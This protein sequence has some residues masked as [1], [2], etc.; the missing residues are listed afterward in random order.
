MTAME[1]ILLGCALALLLWWSTHELCFTQFVFLW[2]AVFACWWATAKYLEYNSITAR[3][4]RE[5]ARYKPEP[6]KT[7]NVIRARVYKR[8]PPPPTSRLPDEPP[9]PV[10]QQTEV[11]PPPTSQP[12]ASRP[13]V[14][15][16]PVSEPPVSGPPI[17][18]PPVS[19][20]Q[21]MRPQAAWPYVSQLPGSCQTV[22]AQ[23]AVS[24]VAAVL[25]PPPSRQTKMPRPP[26]SQKT[27]ELCPPTSQ[28]TMESCPPTSQQTVELSPPIPQ[29]SERLS[30][31][32]LQ[33]TAPQ[34][35]EPP[36]LPTLQRSEEPEDLS[37]RYPSSN[38]LALEPIFKMLWT[39]EKAHRIVD[40]KWLGVL[41]SPSGAFI[42]WPIK[43]GW[44]LRRRFCFSPEAEAFADRMR[45]KPT[46][47]ATVSLDRPN[48]S[49]MVATTRSLGSVL[50][51]IYSP[52]MIHS[53]YWAYSSMG[54]Q[55]SDWYVEPINMDKALLACFCAHQ[56]VAKLPW[57]Y[58]FNCGRVEDLYMA[59]HYSDLVAY[60]ALNHYG[61]EDIHE[62]SK[63]PD[64]QSAEPTTNID[65]VDSGKATSA[66]LS[67][68]D[69]DDS[70]SSTGITHNEPL[71]ISRQPVE[72]VSADGAT[73]GVAADANNAGAAVQPVGPIAST[74]RSSSESPASNTS[75]EMAHKSVAEKVAEND[76]GPRS[77]S[78]ARNIANESS[79]VLPASNTSSRTDE[80]CHTSIDSEPPKVRRNS[81]PVVVTKATSKPERRRASN[82]NGAVT[83]A[84]TARPNEPASTALIATQVHTVAET[85]GRVAEPAAM[86]IATQSAML[87]SSKS[88]KGQDA[89]VADAVANSSNSSGPSDSTGEVVVNVPTKQEHPVATSTIVHSATPLPTPF[90]TKQ[91]AG[92]VTKPSG[93]VQT[94][95][96]GSN[97]VLP[98]GKVTM[99][100]GE[101]FASSYVGHQDMLIN[102]GLQP[103]EPFTTDTFMRD[104]EPPTTD[105][106]VEDAE[107]LTTDMVM[108]EAESLVPG[109]AMQDA[110]MLNDAGT[111]QAMLPPTVDAEMDTVV[112]AVPG[113]EVEERPLTVNDLE[114]A[115]GQPTVSLGNEAAEPPT[116][117]DVGMEGDFSD[118]GQDMVLSGDE[119]VEKHKP[120]F[121]TETVN[122]KMAQLGRTFSQPRRRRLANTVVPTLLPNTVF[123]VPG[124]IP[125]NFAFS[126][127]RATINVPVF[128]SGNDAIA[129]INS[130][131]GANAYPIGQVAS[132]PL[133]EIS[134]AGIDALQ[135]GLINMEAGNNMLTGGEADAR[136]FMIRLSSQYVANNM[137]NAQLAGTSS[138][139]PRLPNP[140]DFELS[141]NEGLG[142]ELG[143]LAKEIEADLMDDLHDT[144][145][146]ADAGGYAQLVDNTVNG[147][148][149]DYDCNQVNRE[150]SAD[151]VL[152]FLESLDSHTY[153]WFING[154][155]QP[156]PPVISTMGSMGADVLQFNVNG[157]TVADNTLL[158]NAPGN[159]TIPSDLL[160]S[161]LDN[162]PPTNPVADGQI[163]DCDFEAIFQELNRLAALPGPAVPTGA[164][165][166]VP[167][168]PAAPEAP[169]LHG[170]GTDVVPV[171]PNQGAV[172]EA[173]TND[174]LDT[175]LCMIDTISD[176]DF[177]RLCAG[178]ESKGIDIATELQ[179]V[180]SMVT[181]PTTPVPPAENTGA[182]ESGSGSSV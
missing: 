83:P 141:D 52:G 44:D 36:S 58:L 16:P 8:N 30:S 131:S 167:A 113:M 61:D 22:V 178:L 122:A 176:A 181:A 114:M 175:L 87:C 74:S 129:W 98:G 3:Y 84:P 170:Q 72:S 104:V 4:Y 179:I 88:N 62:K 143:D 40:G 117:D 119:E 96:P 82:S 108:E 126:T 56:L 45:G 81:A 97:G 24:H 76:D 127:P 63:S 142:E 161:G 105:M 68:S 20:P 75:G 154:V 103:V 155:P 157:T 102:A 162:L 173:P 59:M 48:Q 71:T 39:P 177:A 138:T 130:N 27:M 107:P 169:S 166:A 168:V 18:R 15:G 164:V 99:Q 67:S 172:A 10:S 60:G 100:A 134:Q 70:P 9:P 112:P 13:P 38:S 120:V 137:G 69:R 43:I 146:N 54:G 51:E 21:S 64:K 145:N 118:I 65:I 57:S 5:L 109:T 111:V 91:A 89:D 2:T 14:S 34:Q 95:V 165:P 50:T 47:L 23:P 28:Q 35:A 1:R 31:P 156:V 123:P 149:L 29:R 163:S 85:G 41:E 73:E 78:S 11:P 136:D 53:H 147:T 26:A 80:A 140:D 55:Y 106:A 132:V 135:R 49:F 128:S 90:V 133:P 125:P 124:A 121:D 174:D 101:P 139:Q 180:P 6:R 93:S 153:N 159:G 151:D 12:P 25:C 92:P 42:T 116:K 77:E 152:Y 66:P 32:G 171:V 182:N 19:R 150:I 7:R 79:G 160:F 115:K 17:S 94:M 158:D 46:I 110:E 37:L 144:V 86:D 33:E 148:N